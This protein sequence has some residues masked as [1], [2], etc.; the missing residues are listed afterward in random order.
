MDTRTGQIPSQLYRCLQLWLVLASRCGTIYFLCA[1]EL[2]PSDRCNCDSGIQD[3]S[4]CH[5]GFL[6][7]ADPNHVT[8]A[9]AS[10]LLLFCCVRVVGI[11]A[12]FSKTSAAVKRCIRRQS[13]R[14]YCASFSTYCGDVSFCWC[15]LTRCCSARHGKTYMQETMMECALFVSELCCDGESVGF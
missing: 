3:R 6:S 12:L 1:Q 10:L 11:V 15:W 9:F 13:K 4:D 5:C 8:S 2:Q 7:T 14:V